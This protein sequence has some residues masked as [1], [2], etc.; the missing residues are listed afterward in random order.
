MAA[1]VCRAVEPPIDLVA[2]AAR[3]Q[4]VRAINALSRRV[5]AF[6]RAVRVL[7]PQGTLTDEFARVTAGLPVA[8]EAMET[9]FRAAVSELHQHDLPSIF[10]LDELGYTQ[11][12]ARSTKRTVTA[13]INDVLDN[14]QKYVLTEPQRAAVNAGKSIW[15]DMK[16]YKK[17]FGGKEQHEDWFPREIKHYVDAKGNILTKDAGPGGYGGG[18][19]QGSR[20][21]KGS[22]AKVGED[23][24]TADQMV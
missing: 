7:N 15:R 4:S 17:Q 12:K 22:R 5:P 11:I 2:H 20:S 3:L 18:G 24:Q 9:R 21:T 16:E 6:G 23:I 14:P 1:P 13:H 10:K 19:I 8:R